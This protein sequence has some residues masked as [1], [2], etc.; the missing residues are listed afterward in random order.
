MLTIVALQVVGILLVLGIGYWMD[1]KRPTKLEEG[2]KL[3]NL[4]IFDL[5]E[6]R[7]SNPRLAKSVLENRNLIYCRD[8]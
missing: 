3:G 4:E 7:A 2:T 8:F 6:C 1:G 5:V